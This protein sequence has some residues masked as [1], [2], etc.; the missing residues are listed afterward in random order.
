MDL[1]LNEMT[2]LSTISDHLLLEKYSRLKQLLLDMKQVI[3]AYSG[4]IDSAFLLKVA[5]ITLKDHC[6]ALTAISE[7][8]A[9]WER[10]EAQKLA[11]EIG[12]KHIEVYTKELENP[13]YRA[14]VGD[15][16]Y[17]CKT[18][19]FDMAVFAQTEYPGVLC[20]GAI[21]DDLGDDRP[22][23][24]AAQERGVR[25][26][27]IEAGLY[28]SD[29][30]VLAKALGLRI[31]DKPASACLSS[32]FPYGTQIDAKKLDQI[33]RCEGQIR[34]LGLIHFR[35]RFHEKLL[36]LEFGQV[37]L[38]RV[39]AD[40]QLREALIKIGKS[41]GFQY[42]TLDLAG[43]RMAGQTEMESGLVQIK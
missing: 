24:K 21:S 4:G 10:E 3:I 18:A 23:M 9:P 14:N 30:R 6:L 26:P 37:E 1:N 15:R 8:Y 16:C 41:V 34:A 43:Y 31:W 27:L 40:P 20:Y 17:H 28:K 35:A 25:A 11:Q 32:R 5:Q 33:S 38:D 13:S 36:R 42:V 7:S 22:G 2:S 29:I 19:L 39:F 12:A